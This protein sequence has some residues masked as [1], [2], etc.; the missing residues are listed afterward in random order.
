[1]GITISS[2]AGLLISAAVLG[3][4]LGAVYDVFRIFR[5]ATR[6]GKVA[7]FFLDILYWLVCASATFIFLLVQNEGKPRFMAVLMI[8]AGAALYY[9]TVGA[10]VIRRA[11]AVDAGTRRAAR[12]AAAAAARPVKRLSGAAGKGLRKRGRAA[13]GMIKKGNKV[14]KIRLKVYKHMMYNL[15]QPAKK[16]GATG[17]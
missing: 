8:V 9:A 4:A 11:A 17:K 6:S 2:Q 1:M 3:F 15:L 16:P 14:L 7:V 10:I 12:R 13:G 5:V